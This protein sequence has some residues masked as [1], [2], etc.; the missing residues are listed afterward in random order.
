MIYDCPSCGAA[1]IFDPE[2]G[3]MRCNSCGN[4]Y[5]PYELH[6]R[7]TQ[8]H[9]AESEQLHAATSL[10]RQGFD[11][12]SQLPDSAETSGSSS[13][14]GSTMECSIYTCTACGAH[15]AVNDVEVSTFCSYC[16]QPTVVFDRIASTKKPKYIIPFSVTKEQ[17]VEMIRSRLSMGDFIPEEIRRFPVE[18]VRGIYVPFWLYDLHYRDR[19]YIRGKRDK[20]DY[21]FYRDAECEFRRLT[22]DASFPLNNES[23]QRLE[24]YHMENLKEFTQEYLSG[25]YADQYDILPIQLNRLAGSRAGLLFNEEIKKTIHAKSLLL[26]HQEPE[27]EIT[28]TESALLPVWFLTLRYEGLPYTILVN[29]QT[30]KVIGAVPFQKEKAVILFLAFGIPLSILFTFLFSIL[31]SGQTNEYGF[32]LVGM[33]LMAGGISFACGIDNWKRI[34]ISTRLTGLA[35]TSRFVKERQEE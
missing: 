27:Y 26:L 17:A 30:G 10:H 5:E 7:K 6:N 8:N 2:S 13:D 23:S 20:K 15:I 1:L 12:D 24:P 31:L 19:Q 11:M 16:G 32:R 14:F 29:G 9:F 35:E 22:L 18:R 4:S 21:Y 33:L 3:N 28:G 25:F 34:R